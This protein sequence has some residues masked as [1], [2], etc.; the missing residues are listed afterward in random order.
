MS[1]ISE[2]QKLADKLTEALPPPLHPLGTQRVDL[3][4]GR[5][6]VTRA[7]MGMFAVRVEYTTTQNEKILY[8]VDNE[9]IGYPQAIQTAIKFAVQVAN[10]HRH[11]W[12]PI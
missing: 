9:I 4:K 1:S 3:V 2:L 11:Y 8:R 7:G 6:V 12:Q 10:S 5:W